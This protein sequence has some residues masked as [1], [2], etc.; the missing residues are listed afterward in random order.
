VFS[1]L[2]ILA[3]AWA[4]SRSASSVPSSTGGAASTVASNQALTSVASPPTGAGTRARDGASSSA[5]S[6]GRPLSISLREFS[7]YP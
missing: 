7:G 2:A 5:A 6:S 4:A 1:A 3:Q